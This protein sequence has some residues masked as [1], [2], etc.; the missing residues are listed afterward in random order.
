MV[1]R[2]CE[3]NTICKIKN[4]QYDGVCDEELIRMLRKCGSKK[5]CLECEY[6][7]VADTEVCDSVLMQ[8]AKRLETYSKIINNSCFEVVNRG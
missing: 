7:M 1:C 6:A 4:K 2:I 5:S 8:A 3:H